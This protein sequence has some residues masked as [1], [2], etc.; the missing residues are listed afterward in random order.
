MTSQTSHLFSSAESEQIQ[1]LLKHPEED[2]QEIIRI[3]EKKVEEGYQMLKESESKL[4]KSE[5]RFRSM[6]EQTTDAVFCY[7][8]NPPIPTNL[9]VGEQVKCLYDGILVDCNLTCARSYGADSVEDVIGRKLTDLFGTIPHSL[10]KLFRDMVEGGYHMVDGVGIEK[11]PNGEERFFLNNAHSVIENNMLIRV[12]GTFRDITE[13]KTTEQ[14]LKESEEMFRN[15]TENSSMGISIAQDNQIKYVNKQAAEMLGYTVDEMSGWSFN[16]VL[17][18]IYP[19]DLGEVTKGMRKTL[20][21]APDALEH[22]EY[23]VSKKSGELIWVD[24][25]SSQIIFEGKPAF[26]IISIDITDRKIIGERLKESEENFRTIAEDSHLAITILQDD[27]VK[28][29]NQKMADMFGYDRE[30]MLTWTP[31]EYAKTVAEDSLEFIMEQAR[32]KQIGDPDVIIQYPIHCVKSSGEKFWVDNISTTINYNGHPAD[33]VTIIDTTDKRKAEQK[34]KESEEK[35]RTITEESLIGICIIQDDVIK[36]INQEMSDMFGYTIEEVLNW[37]P[38]EVFKVL[39]PETRELVME[40]TLKKQA[41]ESGVLTHY[42]VQMINKKGELFWVDNISKTITYEGRPA[43]LVTQVDITE[44]LKA[45]QELIKLNQLKSEILRRTSHELK[46][47]LVSIK[48]F[49]ELLLQVHRDKL[50]ALVI[51][52]LNEIEQGCTRLETLIGDILKTAELE[53]GVIQ[54]NILEEDLSFLIKVCVNEIKGFSKLRNHKI[55]LNIHEALVTHFE[56][57][58]IHQVIGN[59][60]NNAV[61]YTPPS[62]IIDINSEIREDFIVL[63]ITDNGIGFTEEEKSRIFKQFGKIE[64]YGQGLDII[65]EGSGFGLFISKKI[66]ELHGGDIWVESEG[67]NKGSTFFFSLPLHE[68]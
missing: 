35:F 38:G 61:K 60:L 34:L 48:G 52:T 32:K 41:G 55:N 66:V 57:E 28:Y 4:K 7:E 67:R 43:D 47:P 50:D 15:I 37:E 39:G 59:L 26:L 46:T 51:S 14:L 31:K 10:D 56:K 19:D 5:Q 8:Y 62:G 11:L 29:T 64:R 20:T 3:L 33:L 63:S 68:K 30:E 25:F 16:K 65:A 45:Q 36:Y 23:R 42:K 53:S 58:Q 17:K 9:L 1:N 2:L 54:P 40:Q 18:A 21:S 49:T 22:L 13:R 44:R 12:W 27:V 6:I 24:S